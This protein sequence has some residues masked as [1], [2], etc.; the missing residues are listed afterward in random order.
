MYLNS[1]QIYLNSCKIFM[2]LKKKYAIQ[3][4]NS[5]IDLINY[6]QIFA[7][8]KLISEFKYISKFKM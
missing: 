8:L 2:N 6:K 5:D 1:P 3:F 4:W 7:Q